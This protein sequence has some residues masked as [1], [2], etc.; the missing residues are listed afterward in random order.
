M[1]G[2]QA[3]FFEKQMY[4]SSKVPGNTEHNDSIYRRSKTHN[5]D[6]VSKQ[7]N[8]QRSDQGRREMLHRVKGKK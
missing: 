4:L 2:G 7:R 6:M 3:N 5:R 8:V 1:K